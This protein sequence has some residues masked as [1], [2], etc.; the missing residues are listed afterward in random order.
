[1]T[2]THGEQ[3]ACEACGREIIGVRGLGGDEKVM[4]LVV[5]ED[6]LEGNVL[7]VVQSIAIM[8]AKVIGSADVRRYLRERGVR[9]WVNHFAD[10]PERERFRR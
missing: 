7:L 10:C 9:L 4:P 5:D 1:M 3:R 2:L 8:R 6:G